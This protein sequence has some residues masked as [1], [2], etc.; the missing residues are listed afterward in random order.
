MKVSFTAKEYARILELAHMGLRVAASGSEEP[1]AV[2][3]RYA[4]VEQKLLALATPLG[5]ADLVEEV[6]EGDFVPSEKLETGVAAEKLE[7]F[8]EGIFWREL[9]ERLAERDLRAELGATKLSET[10][11]EEE[12][13]RLEE[14]EDNYWREFEAQGTDHLMLL[15]GG[16]G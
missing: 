7:E 4:E 2:P 14:I 6:G 16:R 11:S 10:L 5:C 12:T 8:G 13:R 1:E 9:V 3:E 15:K